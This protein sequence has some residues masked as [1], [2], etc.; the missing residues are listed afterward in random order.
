MLNVTNQNTPSSLLPT[1]VSSPVATALRGNGANIM[2]SDRQSHSG[3]LGSENVKHLNRDYVTN[4]QGKVLK[5]VRQAPSAISSEQFLAAKA[6]MS[7]G[8]QHNAMATKIS[9][10]SNLYSEAP[11]FRDQVDILA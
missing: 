3:V 2:P 11:R 6:M 1:P 9:H 10:I 7:P 8:F 4:F 5:H